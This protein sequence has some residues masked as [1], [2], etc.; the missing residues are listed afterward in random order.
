MKRSEMLILL[1][2]GHGIDTAGKRSP[3]FSDGSQLFEYEFNRD[4]VKRI[5][6]KLADYKLQSVIIVP[7]E[8]DVSL[9]TRCAR[10]NNL[11]KNNRVILISVHANAYGDGSKFNNATGW[12]AYTSKGLTESDVICKYLYQAADEVLASKFKIRKSQ[13]YS[14]HKD[15]VGQEEDFKILVSTTCPA[16][17]VENLFM[18]NKT[19]AEFLMTEEGR[20]TI[21]EVIFRGIYY[22]LHSVE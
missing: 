3:K 16:V 5:H 14:D 17:L 18:T 1:D 7:E 6:K 10:V 20:E 15:L 21:A 13:N 2:N 19:D 22:Y 9:Q 11:A 12:S 4:I 8:N